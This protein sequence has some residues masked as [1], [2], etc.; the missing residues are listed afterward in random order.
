LNHL[1]LAHRN[2]FFLSQ[3]QLGERGTHKE[4]SDTITSAGHPSVRPLGIREWEN[5]KWLL[6]NGTSGGHYVWWAF[7]RPTAHNTRREKT[8]EKENSRSLDAV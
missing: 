1:A 3:T 8:K 7:P 2:V 4:K 6:A 5:R